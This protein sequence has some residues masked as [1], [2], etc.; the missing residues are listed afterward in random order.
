MSDLMKIP[1]GERGEIRL[2]NIDLPRSDIDAFTGEDDEAVGPKVLDALGISELNPDGVEIFDVDDLEGL[3]LYGY[4]VQGLGVAEAD[5]KASRRE[6]DALDG[7]V[8]VLLSRAFGGKP[9]SLKTKSPLRWVGTFSEERAKVNFEPLP[10]E[11]AKGVTETPKADIPKSPHL[12]VLV[13]I[14]ALPIFALIIGLVVW[15]A[16]R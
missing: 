1:A 6:I 15:L 4:M 5:L 7:F 12:T 2:F 16:L 13:A 3:G 14:I 10:T 9:A 11:S 8:L